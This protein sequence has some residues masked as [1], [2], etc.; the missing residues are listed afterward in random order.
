MYTT[1]IAERHRFHYPPF[2]RLIQLT[3]MHK[4]EQTLDKAAEDLGGR[5]KRAF[6]KKVLGPEYPPV[7]RIRNMYLKQLLVK[8]DRNQQLRQAKDKLLHVVE[9][10]RE[11]H[12]YKQLRVVINVDPA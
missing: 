12:M 6:P 1:Q 10:F 7:S 11:N 5:L 9:T 8:L 3:I 2:S 4:E